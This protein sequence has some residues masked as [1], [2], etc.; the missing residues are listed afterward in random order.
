VGRPQTEVIMTWVCREKDRERLS[1]LSSSSSLRPLYEPPRWRYSSSSGEGMREKRQTSFSS[2]GRRG[3]GDRISHC[4]DH[5]PHSRKEE[6]EASQLGPSLLSASSLSARA[7]SL[8]QPFPSPLSPSLRSNG[9][10]FP[11]PPSS[12]SL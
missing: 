10:A 7:R 1:L 2:A 8:A 11:P 3:M 9:D 12:L 5:P 4:D 6:E